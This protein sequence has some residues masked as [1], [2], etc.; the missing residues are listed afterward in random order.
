MAPFKDLL[1]GQ[2]KVFDQTRGADHELHTSFTTDMKRCMLIYGNDSIARVLP[3]FQKDS[4]V[5]LTSAL[6]R[7]RMMD[8]Y[9]Y[10]IRMLNFVP[11]K[12]RL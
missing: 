9:R 5:K 4:D 10:T 6:A 1:H 3:S 2:K 11:R 8:S 12:E 7:E